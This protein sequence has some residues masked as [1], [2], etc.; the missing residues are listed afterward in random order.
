MRS[1]Q[2]G[3]S[4]TVLPS[5]Y[6]W[7]WHAGRPSI[8]L[9]NGWINAS[10]QQEG[11]QRVRSLNFRSVLMWEEYA[12]WAWGPSEDQLSFGK[13]WQESQ[14]NRRSSGYLSRPLGRGKAPGWQ[15]LHEARQ[16]GS[17]EIRVSSGP[18][19]WMCVNVGVGPVQW[20]VWKERAWLSL[21][22]IRGCL[23]QQRTV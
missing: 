23:A 20:W 13:L 5:T 14:G 8:C 3:R 9:Q 7:A 19:V 10:E 2:E 21:A 18:W 12:V 4:V 16:V 6:L 11:W 1:G 22:D 15:C 17:L